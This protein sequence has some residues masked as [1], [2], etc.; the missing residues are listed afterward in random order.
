MVKV[1]NSTTNHQ[2][3]KRE[4]GMGVEAQLDWKENYALY[5]K[6]RWKLLN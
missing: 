2:S 4:T 6:Y 1:R 5:L 3:I